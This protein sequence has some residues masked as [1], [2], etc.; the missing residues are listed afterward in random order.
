MDGLEI[1]R[2]SDVVRIVVVDGFKKRSKRREVGFFRGGSEVRE[3][4]VGYF[5][6]RGWLIA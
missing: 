2:Y 1:M 6:G 3:V 4:I 5:S